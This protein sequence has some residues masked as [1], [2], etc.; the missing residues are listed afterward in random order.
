M[1]R[2]DPAS[3]AQRGMFLVSSAKPL[4]TYLIDPDAMT[5]RNLIVLNGP[6]GIGKSTLARRYVDDHRLAL[7]LDIDQ[8]RAMLSHWQ[9]HLAEAGL[10]ARAIALAAAHAHLARGHDVVVPQFVARAEFLDDIMRVAR[11]EGA[12]YREFVLID[13]KE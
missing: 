4:H 10:S 1:P 2:L 3:H 11:A 5:E 6:P 7:N 12:R 9:S 8:V 13:G